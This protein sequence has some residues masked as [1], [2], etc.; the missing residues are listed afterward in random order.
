MGHILSAIGKQ[1]KKNTKKIQAGGRIHTARP[2]NLPE[3]KKIK[4]KTSKAFSLIQLLA[5]A[6]RKFCH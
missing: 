2:E 1:Y 5:A 6:Y 4:E 3:R